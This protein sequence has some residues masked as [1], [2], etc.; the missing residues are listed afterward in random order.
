M[1]PLFCLRILAHWGN[2]WGLEKLH[3]ASQKRGAVVAGALPWDNIILLYG[4]HSIYHS[5]YLKSRRVEQFLDIPSWIDEQTLSQTAGYYEPFVRVPS[6]KYIMSKYD[7]KQWT[8]NVTYSHSPTNNSILRLAVLSWNN[9]RPRRIAFN[10]WHDDVGPAASSSV[11]ISL[12]RLYY[13]TFNTGKKLTLY[14][15]SNVPRKAVR[16]SLVTL[17]GTII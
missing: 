5:I 11:L 16:Y 17:C 15:M 6:M 3:K 8:N 14:A 1:G 13:L 12:F 9:C 7:D 10:L 4:L 2:S